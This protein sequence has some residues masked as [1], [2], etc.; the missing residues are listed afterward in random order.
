MHEDSTDYLIGHDAGY[1]EAEEKYK[2]RIDQLN[3]DAIVKE[4]HCISCGAGHKHDINNAK[5]PAI[6][7]KDLASTRKVNLDNLKDKVDEAIV[8]LESMKKR[9]GYDTYMDM[10]IEKIIK[11]LK[12]N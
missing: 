11:N 7:L 6:F 8:D 2:S 9:T 12:E 4:S 5:Q 1:K 10:L 3:N